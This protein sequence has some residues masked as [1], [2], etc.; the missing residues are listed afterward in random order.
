[1]HKKFY[2]FLTLCLFPFTA[3]AGGSA[4]VGG[5][6]AVVSPPG[7]GVKSM[8]GWN[9]DL[10]YVGDSYAYSIGFGMGS[11]DQDYSIDERITDNAEYRRNWL[12]LSGGL[13]LWNV[14]GFLVYPTVLFSYGKSRQYRLYEGGFKSPE[15]HWGISATDVETS[16]NTFLFGLAFGRYGGDWPIMHFMFGVGWRQSSERGLLTKSSKSPDDEYDTDFVIDEWNYDIVAGMRLYARVKLLGPVGISVAFEG[17]IAPEDEVYVDWD[18][19]YFKKKVW[20]G[21]DITAWIGPSVAF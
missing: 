14:A 5:S 1:M 16:E 10:S 2:M 20:V 9:G 6:L 15:Y 8:L 18:G 12:L 21:R 4:I 11:A 7:D 13:R 19:D 17:V 3:A